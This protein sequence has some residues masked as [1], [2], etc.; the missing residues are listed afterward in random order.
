M[1]LVGIGCDKDKKVRNC[2]IEEAL[3]TCWR[4]IGMKRAGGK[5]RLPFF[6]FSAQAAA[7]CHDPI[8]GGELSGH[9][10]A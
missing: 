4:K 7:N 10:D 5:N 3:L 6:A 2:A 1:H 9:A 8:P